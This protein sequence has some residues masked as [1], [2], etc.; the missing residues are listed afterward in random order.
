MRFHFYKGNPT[1]NIQFGEI[2][3]SPELQPL[4]FPVLWGNRTM[5]ISNDYILINIRL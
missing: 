3:I 2:H 4:V 1:V 5:H